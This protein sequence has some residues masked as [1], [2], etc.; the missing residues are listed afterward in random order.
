MPGESFLL[1]RHPFLKE[2]PL[3][4]PQIGTREEGED[5][6]YVILITYLDYSESSGFWYDITRR[7]IKR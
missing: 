1:A 5:L 4:Y 6:H 2:F 7:T 3:A